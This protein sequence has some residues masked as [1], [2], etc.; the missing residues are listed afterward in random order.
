VIGDRVKVQN[1][2]SLYGGVTLEDDVF[3]GPSAVFTNIRTPRAPY[4]R[5]DTDGYATTLVRRG[6]TIGANATVVCSTT[7]G[8]WAVIG[9]G[10]VV[11]KDV[12]P[13]RLM[14]GVP[15][16]PAGWA[17]ECGMPLPFN[18]GKAVCDDCGR[19]YRETGDS[20]ERVGA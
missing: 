11:T 9:A 3:C 14:T 18:D 12:P 10:A 2:V 15:A 4:P 17:C 7:I 8:E 13:H 19:K 16:R 5:K 20:I 6:A 1:N